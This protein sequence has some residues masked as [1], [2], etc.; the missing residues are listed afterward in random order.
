MLFPSSKFKFYR[1]KIESDKR[2][3]LKKAF[4][5]L[6]DI[7]K[8]EYLDYNNFTFETIEDD[9]NKQTVFHIKMN[10]RYPINTVNLEVLNTYDYYRPIQIQ[11]AVDS[12]KSEK[13]WRFR[14]LDLYH[15]TLNS[16]QRR[17]FNF[18]SVLAKRFKITIMNHDNQPLQVSNLSIKGLE[19]KLIA[20][21]TEDANYF[22]TYGK[23]NIRKPNYDISKS[24]KNI[25]ATLVP[26]K[27]GNEQ[28]IYKTETQVKSPLFENK[29]WLWTIMA[30]VI[31]VLGGFTMKMMSK[32]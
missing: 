25:P 27:L 19:Y 17:E 8:L 6:A 3:I 20:R 26:L 29:F 18:E 4:V 24:E 10:Q 5:A 2:P 28:V 21:F 16:F 23:K 32:K 7:V 22:L 11:Y 31:L 13:G 12:V 30:V 15:G 14:Y 1:I 9:N